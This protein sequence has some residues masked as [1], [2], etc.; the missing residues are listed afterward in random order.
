MMIDRRR[1]L[2]ATASLAALPVLPA[3]AGRNVLTLE[4]PAFGAS[5]RLAAAGIHDARGLRRQIG[6]VIAEVDAAM[7]PFR[8]DSELSRFNG[9]ATTDWLPV[10]PATQAV[11]AEALRAARLTGDAFNPT[12]GPLV[13]RYGFGPIRE[14]YAGRSDELEL[15][16]AGIRKA[17]AELS[18][19]LCGIAKGY[20]LDRL[21]DT[22]AAWN[23]TDFM[24]ELGGEVLARGQHPGG[25]AWQIGVEAP[26]G[27]GGSIR[28]V[29]A[30]QGAALA[31]SGDAV[32]GYIH[33]GLRYSHIIEPGGRPAGSVLASVTVAAATAM[34]ADALATALYAM[35]PHA[36]PRFAAESG[37]EALFLMHDGGEDV[38]GGFEARLLA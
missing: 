34:T 10:S 25:R 35:G 3:W 19:D 11:V 29:V 15:T 4:G 20:A 32:N 6:T 21:A 17:R 1:F 18:L 37:I 28:H 9:A 30:V 33:R 31:T 8:P 2:L 7:S 36:G 5:W 22:C 13:G 27:E 26:T 12:V 38:V 14:G 24:I 16:E 23:L